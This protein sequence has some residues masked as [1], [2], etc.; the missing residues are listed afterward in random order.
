MIGVKYI[1]SSLDTDRY[2]QYSL[3][4]HLKRLK[5]INQKSPKLFTNKTVH[6]LKK[7][8]NFNTGEE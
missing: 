6:K 1:P 7:N 4:L 3:E 8:K 2:Q 5:E